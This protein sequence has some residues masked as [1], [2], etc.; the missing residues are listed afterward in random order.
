MALITAVLL[1]ILP[2][3]AGAQVRT[4]KV[5]STDSAPIMYAFVTIEGGTG[6]ISDEKGEIS[7]GAGSRK[8]VTLN[9][10]R[11]GYQPWFGTLELPDTA[12][13]LTITLPRLAQAL[14]EVRVTG[15]ASAGPGLQPFCDRWL[16]R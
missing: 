15:R 6:Q 4:L 12:A 1:A 2:S 16:M 9:V 13:T 14:G 5:V 8:T 3:I 10:R 7:L 11:I